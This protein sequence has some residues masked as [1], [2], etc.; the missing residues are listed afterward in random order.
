M[1]IKRNVDCHYFDSHFSLGYLK[2]HK[3]NKSREKQ[4]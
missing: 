2:L 3:L 4:L 1:Y